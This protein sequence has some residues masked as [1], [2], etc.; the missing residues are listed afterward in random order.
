LLVLSL[1]PSSAAVVRCLA[2]MCDPS[3]DCS[4]TWPPDAPSLVLIDDT[5][6]ETRAR[7]PRAVCR[8]LHCAGHEQG[9]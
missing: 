2:Q 1:T 7:E 9:R 8:H 6:E 3:G 5:L 4:G